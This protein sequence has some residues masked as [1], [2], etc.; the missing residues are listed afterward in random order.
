MFQALGAVSVYGVIVIV[1]SVVGVVI[2][3]STAFLHVVVGYVIY[4]VVVVVVVVVWQLSPTVAAT[5]VVII[6]VTKNWAV[7]P[8]IHIHSHH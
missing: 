8:H 6:G 3:K 1:H 2:T 5:I 7:L 4:I